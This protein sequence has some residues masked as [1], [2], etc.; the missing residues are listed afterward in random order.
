[1]DRPSFPLP[2]T[3][4][5]TSRRYQLTGEV[6]ATAG[7]GGLPEGYIFSDGTVVGGGRVIPP[8]HKVIYGPGLPP[9]GYIVKEGGPVSHPDPREDPGY[10]PQRPQTD[11]EYYGDYYAGLSDAYFTGPSSRS[12]DVPK[13]G[14]VAIDAL[15]GSRPD[16]PYHAWVREYQNLTGKI[17]S[18]P[19]SDWV[20][21]SGLTPKGQ[22]QGGTTTALL[23]DPAG[24]SLWTFEQHTVPSIKGTTAAPTRPD[25]SVSVSEAR[26]NQVLAQAQQSLANAN[27]IEAAYAASRNVERAKELVTQSRAPWRAQTRQSFTAQ[28]EVTPQGLTVPVGT[29]KALYAPAGV[30]PAA[31]MTTTTATAAGTGVELDPVFAARHR[32]EAAIAPT[33]A[34][35]TTTTPAVGTETGTTPFQDAETALQ[36]RSSPLR[37]PTSSP[38]RRRRLLTPPQPQQFT[39]PTEAIQTAPLTAPPQPRSSSPR[40]PEPS[41]PATVTVPQ[42]QQFT[43]PAGAIADGDG[44]SSPS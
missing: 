10:T 36:P 43:A 17:G 40:Q 4:G 19:P 15:K 25:F 37:Q 31:A 26:A 13:E 21:P 41:S 22:T 6:G 9:D 27:T 7:K 32:P 2:D 35:A 8:G 23:E 29:T 11:A 20:S 14:P 33:T 1:M 39:A 44:Y 28:A 12:Y 5:G 34:A 16:S 38:S 18:A 42:A 3:T 30:L 24:P